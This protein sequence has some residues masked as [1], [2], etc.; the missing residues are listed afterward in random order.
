MDRS[1]YFFC[2]L[3]SC[4]SSSAGW[5]VYRDQSS[6]A[7]V[8]DDMKP[9]AA[10][11]PSRPTTD[12][13]AV[14]ASSGQPNG[15]D[16]GIDDNEKEEDDFSD[17]MALL[18]NRDNG[19][20]TSA[21]AVGGCTPTATAV[22]PVDTGAQ[23]MACGTPC[24][25]STPVVASN[26]SYGDVTVKT[27]L[28]DVFEEPSGEGDGGY[29][30]GGGGDHVEELLRQY[31]TEMRAQGGEGGDRGGIDTDTCTSNELCQIEEEFNRQKLYR[32]VGRSG[33]SVMCSVCILP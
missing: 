22:G 32:Q 1:L 23:L 3:S 21:L 16:W 11:M 29:G 26:V 19:T 8:L 10:D 20:A 33:G 31:L 17:I 13:N 14:C 5:L 28:V 24:A 7:Y 27:R 30:A 15:T 9:P 18:D 25:P 12:W 6:N 2:C 4:A